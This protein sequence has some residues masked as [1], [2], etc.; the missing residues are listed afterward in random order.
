MQLI[1]GRS[2][3]QRSILKSRLQDVPL[4]VFAALGDGDIL[5]LDSSHVAKTASDVVDYTFRILPALRS[6]V[7]VHIH[8]I[9]YPFEYPRSWIVDENRSWNEAYL[10]R[11]FL[12]ANAGFRVLYLSDWVYKCRRDLFETHMP[13][14]VRYRGGSLWMRKV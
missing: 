1:A 9:F 7:L 11:A 12:H 5:F 13:L 2:A 8:D 10:V 3:D 6:G 4:K 14:C